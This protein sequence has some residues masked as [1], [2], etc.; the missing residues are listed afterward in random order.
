METTCG[1]RRDPFQ[2]YLF[3]SFQGSFFLENLRKPRENGSGF[4]KER[5]LNRMEKEST[6]R[7][8]AFG[9]SESESHRF[10]ARLEG[11][12]VIQSP[13]DNVTEADGHD[14]GTRSFLVAVF[15]EGV[16]LKSRSTTSI[17]RASAGCEMGFAAIHMDKVASQCTRLESWSGHPNQRAKRLWGPARSDV[18]S[19]ATKLYK[20]QCT[21]VRQNMPD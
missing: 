6:P 17:H 19:D 20:A 12:E 16:G 13:S 2:G 4:W 10:P 15:L 11:I 14:A 18:S 9:P 7:S 8:I 5:W 3:H 21:L 1:V